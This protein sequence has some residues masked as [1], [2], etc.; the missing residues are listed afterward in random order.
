MNN[1][2]LF[3]I[4][5]SFP[6]RLFNPCSALLLSFDRHLLRF[7][8]FQEL[9]LFSAI[10]VFIY[11]CFVVQLFCSAIVLLASTNLVCRVLM[12]SDFVC[13][14]L[15]NSSASFSCSSNSAASSLILW[16]LVLEGLAHPLVV[17]H[18]SFVLFLK[19]FVAW[20]IFRLLIALGA[21]LF[22]F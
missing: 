6:T 1:H 13:T 20:L 5:F 8:S 22:F 19:L 11:N 10:L 3:L 21:F 18:Q 16:L 4:F 7:Q 2:N 14:R 12:A 15:A 9:F 17:F